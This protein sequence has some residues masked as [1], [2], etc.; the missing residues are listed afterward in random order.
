ME[1]QTGPI[2]GSDFLAS[3]GM[4]VNMKDSRMNWIGGS[5]ELVRSVVGD[6][7]CSLVLEEQVSTTG[8]ECVVV[9]AKVVNNNGT[10]LTGAA[11][12][13]PDEE[14]VTSTGTLVARV[15]VDASKDRV[16]VQLMFLQGPKCLEKGTVLGE[17]ECIEHSNTPLASSGCPVYAVSHEQ[18]HW[19]FSASSTGQKPDLAHMRKE[20]WS[21]CYCRTGS[22]FRKVPVIWAK[23]LL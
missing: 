5:V 19:L 21:R 15:L 1:T 11:M 13:E 4:I 2:L 8:M 17:L 14:L 18:S 3:H 16:P 6:Q 7:S 23:Q 9:M 10:H 22:C 12:L 20:Y